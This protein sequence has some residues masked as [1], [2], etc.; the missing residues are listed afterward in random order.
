MASSGKGFTA[1]LK[2]PAVY[3]PILA[4]LAV[5]LLGAGGYFIFR[6]W[7]VAVIVALALALIGLMVALLRTIFQQEKEERLGRGIDEHAETAPSAAATAPSM[8]ET[9]RRAVAEIRGSRLGTAG[10]ETMPWILVLG[11]PGAGKTALLRESGLELPAEY[12]RRIG[13]GATQECDWWLAN[14]AIVLDLAGRFLQAEDDE[15]L[16]GWQSL[17]RLLR[18]QRPECGVNSI[19]FAVPVTSLLG[20]SASELEEIALTLRR[21]INEATDLLGVDLPI[22]VL[23]TKCDLLEGFVETVN[24]LP[25]GQLTGSLGWTNDRRIAPDAEELALE[26]LGDML[27]RLEGLL[28]ELILRDPDGTRRRRI[29][30]FPQELDAA[31]Q[32]VAGLVGRAFAPSSYAEAPFLRGIYFTSAQREGVTISPLLHRLGWDSARNRVDGA[33]AAGG[34]FLRDIFSEIIIGD[35]NLAMPISRHGPRTRR[36]AHLGAGFVFALLAGWWLIAFTSNFVAI[37]GLKNEAASVMAGASSLSVLEELR[38][39]IVKQGEQMSV[40]RRGGLGGSIESALERARTTF[41]W[42]FGHEFEAPTKLKLKGIVRGFDDGAFEALAQLAQD[43]TWLG[44]RA[45]ETVAA[46]PEL[47]PYAPVSKNETEMA[48]FRD[49]YDAFVRWSQT[50]ELRVRIDRER[51]IVAGGSGRLLE[52]RRL[53]SW[54]ESSISSYPSATYADIDLPGAAESASHVPGAYTARGWN[55]LVA[56]LIDAID[57]TSGVTSTVVEQF[58]HGYVTRFDDNWRSYLLEAPTPARSDPEVLASPYIELIEQI[59]SNTL[60]ELPRSGEPPSFVT[61]LRELRREEPLEQEPP[62]EGEKAKEPPKPPWT[63]YRA[64]LE[65]VAADV[66]KAEEQ[67]KDALDLA[68]GTAQGE[69]TSFTKALSLIDDIIPAEGDPKAA[70]QL[71]KLASMPILDGASAVF[72]RALGE[73]DRRWGDRIARPFA[74]QLNAGEMSSLYATGSG[75]L[76]K[77]RGDALAHFYSDGRARTLVG[78]R[79]MPLGPRFLRWMKAAEKVQRSLYPGGGRAPRI[80]ARLEGVPSLVHGDSSLLVSRR[81]IRLACDEGEQTFRYLGEGT[82]SYTF[83]WTPDCTELSLRIW[84]LGGD[85]REIELLPRHEWTGPMAFPGF[86]QQ[87]QKQRRNRF[88]W[89]LHFDEPKVEIAMVY[90]LGG[91]DEILSIAHSSPPGSM[92]N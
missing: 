84:A 32:A 50:D 12:A 76:A 1:T 13:T 17:L 28:P 34:I 47:A 24:L 90:R 10:I 8:Q 4:I 15:T 88:V 82:G 60:V 70:A 69:P 56:G 2:K 89:N 61:A 73:L 14:Q 52:L 46:R 49:G 7:L 35:Q 78:D 25:P 20:R 5:V 72:R 81:E 30:S 57:R 19:I 55:G 36:I 39:Q 66:A 22:Y 67:G 44:S 53:E 37:R 58:R 9:F 86:L 83:K 51:E 65:Q 26:G 27:A 92:R 71:R 63:Q 38:S 74:G 16:A 42:G 54:S 80:S 31:V 45:D 33:L 11:E 68:I 87:A 91:G 23:V 64:A 48:A 43:V 3:V 75:K 59:Y 21:R 6:S 77:F 29:F 85:N 40:L 79:R 18:R 41:T 62:K